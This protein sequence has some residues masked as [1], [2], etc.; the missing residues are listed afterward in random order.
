[1]R[2]IDDQLTTRKN[3]VFIVC[4]RVEWYMDYIRQRR[5]QLLGQTMKPG[6]LR[7]F[8]Q[9]L[10]ERECTIN[11]D[12]AASW[13]QE[14]QPTIID[15]RGNLAYKVSTIPN[16]INIPWEL[17][18]TMIDAADPFPKD[19]SL[20]LVCP[21]GEKT[22]RHAAYLRSRGYNAFGLGGGILSWR[23]A[24]HKL[25]KGGS[26]PTGA[27]LSNASAEQLAATR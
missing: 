17:F 14:H 11:V 26:A 19:R 24:G 1:L 20:L 25:V 5:P 27:V 7:A 21:V 4:D 23:N 6:S 9:E 10:N 16:A 2:K 12:A 3:A 15:V 22:I 8:S 18:E 13:I